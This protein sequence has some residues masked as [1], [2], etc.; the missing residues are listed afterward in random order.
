M[1]TVWHRADIEHCHPAITPSTESSLGRH[2]HRMSAPR[3]QRLSFALFPGV[4]DIQHNAW[5]IVGDRSF[6]SEIKCTIFPQE[7]AFPLTL[8]YFFYL[9]FLSPNEIKPLWVFWQCN[10]LGWE[11]E[12]GV[13]VL[14]E[15]DSVRPS[16][17]G[18]LLMLYC[19]PSLVQ[20]TPPS[21]WIR[22]SIIVILKEGLIVV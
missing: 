2:C 14:Y 9:S 10:I 13:G 8:F 22:D 12:G 3:G 11:K 5:N 7:I 21:G 6:S 19:E 20:Q 4:Q 15:W 18:H 17:S 16:T 1:A